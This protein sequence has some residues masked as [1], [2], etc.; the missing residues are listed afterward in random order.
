MSV[1]KSL[2]PR[3]VVL[4]AIL[5]LPSIAVAAND[6]ANFTVT[7]TQMQGA[8]SSTFALCLERAGVNSGSRH[9]CVANELVAVQRRIDETYRAQLAVKSEDEAAIMRNDNLSWMRAR[10]LTCDTKTEALRTSIDLGGPALR[11]SEMNRCLL[12]ESVRR[13]IWLQLRV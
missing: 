9:E 10:E 1:F 5:G 12:Q 2:V 7:P 4:G 3:L 8:V 13:I 6:Y 11:V